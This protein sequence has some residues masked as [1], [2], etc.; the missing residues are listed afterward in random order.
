[1]GRFKLPGTLQAEPKCSEYSN[2]IKPHLQFRAI[3]YLR[4]DIQDVESQN[5]IFSAFSFTGFPSASS[6]ACKSVV[7]SKLSEGCHVQKELTQT[8]SML[9]CS[10]FHM[11]KLQCWSTALGCYGW[12]QFR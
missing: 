11:Q 10:Q 8:Q 6:F 4:P 2:S 1:M 7:D 12:Q 3:W 5:T 9:F